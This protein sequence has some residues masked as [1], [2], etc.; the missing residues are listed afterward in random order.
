MPSEPIQEATA[1]IDRGEIDR[2][3][4]AIADWLRSPV[5]A[6][7]QDDLDPLLTKLTTLGALSVDAATLQRLIDP[8]QSRALA[9]SR[10][11]R[12]KLAEARL[13]L[14]PELRQTAK[15]L[16]D[17]HGLFAG[18]YQRLLDEAELRTGRNGRPNPALV[19]GHALRSIAERLQVAALIASPSPPNAWRHA[20][21]LFHNTRHVSVASAGGSGQ[22]FDPAGV[23]KEILALAI[24][25]PD[26]LTAPELMFAVE[27]IARF[28]SVVEIQDARPA[29][30]DN[31]SYWL[32]PQSDTGPVAVVR[33]PPPENEGTLFVSCLRLGTLAAEQL[34]WL[35]GGAQ[36][37]KLNLMAEASQAR[38]RALLQRMQESWTEPRSRLLHR[39]RNSY[40][41]QVCTGLGAVWKLL[42]AHSE[43]QPMPALSNWIVVNESPAGYALSQVSGEVDGLVNGGVIA[44]RAAEDKP[45]D[46][47]VVRW[48]H[49]DD[50]GQ[51]ELGLQIVA[52]GATPVQVAF[53]NPQRRDPP[54]AGLLLPAVPA[55]RSHEAILAPAGCCSSRRFVLVSGGRKTHVVQGRMLSVDIQTMS[56]ELFQFQPDPY[57]I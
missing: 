23:Y 24:V 46:I 49:A 31:R 57:P 39:R 44:V 41:L 21:A 3:V 8:L 34:R 28:A 18:A 6:A 40:S 53:R 35:E 51:V 56:T 27:Y 29:E 42:L 22:A 37:D 47:C 45:W 14:V 1:E 50:R 55:L 2:R 52:T 36:P 10:A 5:A 20:H 12:P 43:G 16:M 11:L 15:K 38:F 26:R 9:L 54:Q 48:L 17:I 25:Q 4:A 33:R 30:A 19:A 32:E 7:P 13:P